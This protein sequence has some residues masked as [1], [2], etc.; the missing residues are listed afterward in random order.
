MFRTEIAVAAP[1]TSPSEP[2][3]EVASAWWPEMENTWVP[4]GWKD[5]PLRFNVLYNGT[6]IA[7]PVRYP[8]RGQ[9]VQL[10]FVASRDGKPPTTTSSEPYQLRSRDGGVGDQGW[11]DNPAPVLWT[12]SIQEGIV[13]R[14]E[15]FAHLRGGGS[16]QT[17]A[18]PLFAWI[19]LSLEN[20]SSADAFV[21]IRVNQPHL[22]TEMDRYKN[23]VVDPRSSAY[24]GPLRL[25]ATIPA[26]YL[27]LD[28]AGRVRLAAVSA[29]PAMVELVDQ[30]PA[31]PDAY[32]KIAISSGPGGHA[33]LL[34]PLVP[35]DRETADA[36][37]AVG[38]DAALQEADR[39]WS[40]VAP[41]AA[42]VDTPE[43]L[44]NEAARQAVRYCEVIAER[45]PDTGQYALL[46]GS[47]HYEKLWATPTSMN[48]TMILDGLGHH[49]AAD[50]YLE[51]FRQEQGTIVPPGKAY[52]QHA[53]HLATPRSF[54]SIDWLTDHGA[55]LYAAAHHAL[56]T[57]DP[58]FI[59]RWT[60]PIL[61]AC[62]F[63]RDFRTSSTH[64]GVK[65]ILPAA[66]PTDT[67]VQEQSVWTDGW[68]YKGLSTAVR[69]LKR[70]NH[71]RAEEFAREA[72]AYRESFRRGDTRRHATNARV[73]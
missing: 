54:T 23:L 65:G 9:G 62:E 26:K 16:L 55:I 52:H 36:E 59:E 53:G 33:D 47:W 60:E 32:L 35:A 73:D 7:Q 2:N 20:S 51:I 15:V 45:H 50:K 48:I 42:H 14:Q 19:R 72:D 18:E 21:L 22:Q 29:S 34:V 71:P 41:T 38:Y 49:P 17:G 8:A 27:L 6:L 68:N 28:D 37:I 61:K 12:R 56:V 10:T 5:H 4:I 67:G 63:I 44:V 57:D 58:Q 3:V 11:T 64:S 69:L 30:R 31:G 1:P 40:A 24:P 39:F 46:S 66:V 43:R 70:I 25:E 13:L